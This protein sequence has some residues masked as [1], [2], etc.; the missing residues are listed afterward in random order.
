MKLTIVGPNDD[1]RHLDQADPISTPQ[2]VAHSSG[3]GGR[4][5]K[6]CTESI[7]KMLVQR[8]NN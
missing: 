3:G 5:G 4:V 7:F 1:S 2:A 6:N 8:E